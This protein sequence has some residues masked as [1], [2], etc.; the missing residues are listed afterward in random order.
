MDIHRLSEAYIVTVRSGIVSLPA[1]RDRVVPPTQVEV[2]AVLDE[3]V[4]HAPPDPFY[5]FIDGRRTWVVRASNTE[6]TASYGMLA[7]GRPILPAL[8]SSQAMTELRAWIEEVASVRWW[9]L[10]GDDWRALRPLL[11]CVA[12]EDRITVLGERDGLTKRATRFLR[13]YRGKYVMKH[14][15]H[16]GV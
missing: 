1:D 6:Q 14:I 13:W 12:G 15:R 9:L 5:D 8:L 16:A 4:W 2:R 10:R 7:R 3:P 11:E